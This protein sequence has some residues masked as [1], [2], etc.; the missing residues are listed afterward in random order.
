MSG[1]SSSHSL[2]E[3]VRA[4]FAVVQSAMADNRFAHAHIIAAPNMEWGVLL[5]RLILQHL[6]CDQPAKPCGECRGC[7]LVETRRHADVVWLEPEMK[8]RVIGIDPMRETN[9]FLRQTSFEGGWKAAVLVHADR[10]NESAANAFLKTLEEPPDRCVMLLVTDSPQALLPTILSR[11]QMIPVGLVAGTQTRSKVETAMLDWLVRRAGRRSPLEQSAWISAVLR[12]VRERAEAA[13]KE[14]AG[15]EDVEED[16]F[17]ARVESQVKGARSEV[18]RT[19]YQW[20][21]DVMVLAQG[22][23]DEDLFYPEHPDAIRAQGQG[24]TLAAQLDRLERVSRA[25]RLLEGNV[26][27]ASVWEAVLP[28]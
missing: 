13:E 25:T 5:A 2:P 8:S 4:A 14:R 11:C 20:E 3:P 18:L 23:S 28:A 24:L 22:G 7:Q 12:E 21:R 1:I 26:P 6:F 9:N 17:K 27:E 19:I 10:M 16:V 15:E